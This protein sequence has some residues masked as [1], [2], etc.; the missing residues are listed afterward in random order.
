MF[1][2]H[3]ATG[4]VTK[5]SVLS[6]RIKNAAKHREQHN[7]V[8]THTHTQIHRQ[9]RLRKLHSHQISTTSCFYT[10]LSALRMEARASTHLASTNNK[11]KAHSHDNLQLSMSCKILPSRRIFGSHDGKYEDGRLLGCSAAKYGESLPTFQ[12]TFLPPSSG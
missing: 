9:T 8:A 4:D 5:Y 6:L 10:T 1:Q 11:C 7:R 3:F 12:R 2:P